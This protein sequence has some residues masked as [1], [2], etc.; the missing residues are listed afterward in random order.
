MNTI[1]KKI[2]QQ[3]KYNFIII[4]M[5]GS[6]KSK[7]CLFSDKSLNYLIYSGI[8][9]KYVNIL[10]NNDIY[11]ELPIFS[12]WPTF[13]Q[14][15]INNKLIGGFDIIYDLYKNGNLKKILKK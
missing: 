13:P 6:P 5:K 8:N 4:Y 14:I 1:I 10:E 11:L 12:K 2:K 9:F 15:W 3:I 7:M